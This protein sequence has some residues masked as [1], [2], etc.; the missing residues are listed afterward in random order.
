MQL[1]TPARLAS[2]SQKTSARLI[3]AACQHVRDT[4]SATILLDPVP[5]RMREYS[6]PNESRMQPD[7]R[8]LSA[9]LFHV[10]TTE[11]DMT[12]EVL[13]FVRNLPDQSID[14]IGFVTG[15]RGEIMVQLHETF[16]GESKEVEA[17]LLSDGTLRVLAIAATLLSAPQGALVVIEEIDNGVHPS[18]AQ[19]LLERIESIAQRRRLRVLVTTHNP[20][21]MDALADRAMDNAVVCYRDATSGRSKLVRLQDLPR[22]PALAIQGPLGHLVSKR[23]LDRYL[24][25]AA[26]DPPDPATYFSR[27]AGEP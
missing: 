8:N 2:A 1:T 6:Y 20:S 27:L 9:V 13:S 11:P 12:D 10:C 3:P 18:R 5:S 24:P 22:Y 26:S 19:A 4:L 16:G 7:G 25:G 15:P 23:V 14:E 17:A 21:L